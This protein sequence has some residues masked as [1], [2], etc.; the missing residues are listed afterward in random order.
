MAAKTI[1]DAQMMKAKKQAAELLRIREASQPGDDVD[2]RA[3]QIVSD[4][5]GDPDPL[6]LHALVIALVQFGWMS[7]DFLTRSTER[8]ELDAN[9]LERLIELFQSDAAG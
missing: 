9:E 7:A 3:L 4:A 1:S 5:V 6:T 8:H 2:P